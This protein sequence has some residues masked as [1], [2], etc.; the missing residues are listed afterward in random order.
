VRVSICTSIL[1]KNHH[2]NTQT[3]LKDAKN[4]A[5]QELLPKKVIVP[6]MKGDNHRERIYTPEITL[7]AFLSQAIGEDKSQ[8][9]AVS[10]IVATSIAN[11]ESAPSANTSAFSQARSN[12]DEESISLLAKNTAQEVVAHLP[13]EWLWKQKRIKI[14]DGST[15]SMPDTPSNQE[16][17][18]QSK[19]QKAGVGFPIARMVA[20]IDYATGVLLDLAQG[21]CKGKETGEHALLRQL[22]PTLTPNDLLLG[23]RYY[24]SYFLMATLMMLGISGVFPLH[25][26]RHP[27]FRTGTILGKKDH[28]VSWKKPAKIPNWMTREEYNAFPNEISVREVAVEIKQQGFR[29][30][31]FILVSTLLDSR[32]VSKTAL[33]SLYSCRWFIELSLRALKETMGMD[34]LRGKTPSMIRKELWVHLLAYNLIRRWMAQAAWC[35]GKA[36]AT[37]SFKLTLQLLRAF[38]SFALLATPEQRNQIALSIASKTVANRPGR[39]EPRRVKRRPKPF[40]LLQM[41][42]GLYK[43][44]A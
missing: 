9:A 43:N 40:P 24:S 17:Y 39:E 18:P 14:V 13:K 28:I 37:L 1:S 44:G 32:E 42:R 10:R 25:H 21:P 36:V 5:F 30:K 38:D 16:A 23:D 15:V 12:L 29:A 20:L 41:A 6:L 8:Q 33:A 35:S 34:I 4:L 31:T 7:W 11:G 22:L 3:K 19:C 2:L 26:T 27:D